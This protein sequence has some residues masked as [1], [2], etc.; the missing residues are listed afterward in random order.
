M[1][2]LKNL[3]PRKNLLDKNKREKVI[4]KIADAID[5]HEDSVG[6]AFAHQSDK[7]LQSFAKKADFAIKGCWA[8]NLLTGASGLPFLAVAAGVISIPMLPLLAWTAASAAFFYMGARAFG[9]VLTDYEKDVKDFVII[10]KRI[11]RGEIAPK[12]GQVCK[13]TKSLSQTTSVPVSVISSAKLADADLEKQALK[14]QENFKKCV[15]LN[16]A[17]V[18]FGTP[19]VMDTTLAITNYK[20]VNLSADVP[21][22]INIHF[23]ILNIKEA[24]SPYD[25]LAYA[26]GISGVIASSVA[27]RF[28]GAKIDKIGQN[29]RDHASGHYA[30]RNPQQLTTLQPVL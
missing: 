8:A 19:L 21:S 16:T 22:N 28:F 18:G 26:I 15:L 23:Q 30:P 7:D 1:F 17:C 11:A 13:H 10:G 29:I 5:M 2:F 9:S 24:I 6:E 12:S 4:Q 20:P 3:L 27:C 14:A 25:C